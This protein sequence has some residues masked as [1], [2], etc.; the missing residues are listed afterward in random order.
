MKMFKWL[1]EL[2]DKFYYFN[3][4]EKQIVHFL[5]DVHKSISKTTLL[6]PV[7][8]FDKQ[9]I[10][11]E[12]EQFKIHIVTKRSRYDDRF[13]LDISKCRLND[14]QFPDTSLINDWL[15]EIFRKCGRIY[16][17]RIDKYNLDKII[18]KIRR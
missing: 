3:D 7:I 12:Y 2:W 17:K 6:R 9:S 10:T 14:T 13:D 15:Y 1:I 16:N 8:Q 4:N 18:Q 11:I 5:K